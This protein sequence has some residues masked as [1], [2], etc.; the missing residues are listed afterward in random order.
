M[1]SEL[2]TTTIS[3]AGAQ[4]E[5]M[6]LF[7]LLRENPNHLYRHSL[8][9]SLYSVLIAKAIGW[10]SP[11]TLVRLSLCGMLHDIGKKELSPE[12]LSKPRIE[13]S[14]S[15]LKDLESHAHRGMNILLHTPNLPEEVA[16]VAFQHHEDNKGLG[17]PQR[18]TKNKIIPIARLVGFA[19][20]F[21]DLVFDSPGYS[22]I[23]PNEAI[24]RMTMTNAGRYDDDFL[25]AM[26]KLLKGE[27]PI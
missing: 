18:L 26:T 15:E 16:A 27:V 17:F 13:L 24:K 3:V 6:K 1:A 2:V 14:P 8:A 20:A 23:D 10:K 4:Q 7:S 9:V 21:C 19:N 25:N 12:L 5:V 11:R 22:G